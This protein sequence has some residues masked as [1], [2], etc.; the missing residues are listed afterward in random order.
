MPRILRI[1]DLLIMLGFAA[2]LWISELCSISS[3]I[4]LVIS[5]VFIIYVAVKVVATI[6]LNKKTKHIG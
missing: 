4:R 1:L 3:N 6:I 5:V 2:W